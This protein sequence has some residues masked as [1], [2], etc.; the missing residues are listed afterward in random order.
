MR[1]L[2]RVDRTNMS[3]AVLPVGDHVRE[4]FDADMYSRHDE[5]YKNSF[6]CNCSKIW[7]E[8]IFTVTSPMCYVMYVTYYIER[9]LFR[10]QS[11]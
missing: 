9:V 5:Q 8:R 4:Y 7:L 3:A 11:A 1:A 6:T 10:V 2:G